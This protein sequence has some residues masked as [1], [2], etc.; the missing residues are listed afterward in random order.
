[1]SQKLVTDY[2]INTKGTDENI[3]DGIQ[4][5]ER[6]LFYRYTGWRGTSQ[7]NENPKSSN[8]AE[9]T[10]ETLPDFLYLKFLICRKRII[11]KRHRKMSE[12]FLLLFTFNNCLC[13]FEYN[14]D[15]RSFR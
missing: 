1:M 13:K 3:V 2:K 8:L 14:K 5:Y 12:S 4:G 6:F 11:I 10:L 7:N 15:I 9:T